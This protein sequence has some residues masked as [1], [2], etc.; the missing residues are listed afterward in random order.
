MS[1]RRKAERFRA[2]RVFGR[3]LAAARRLADVGSLRRAPPARLERRNRAPHHERTLHSDLPPVHRPPRQR[4]RARGARSPARRSSSRAAPATSAA[5][6]SRG[7]LER[8]YRV[9]VLD[10][11]YLGEDAAGGLPRPHRGGP[12]PTCATSPPSALD[13]V[14]GVIHLAGLSNDPTA[15]YDPE[16][17]WQMNAVATETLGRACVERGIER[18][19]FASS[20]SLYDGLPP[21]MHDETRRSSR[22]APTRPPSATA[23]RRCSSSVDEGLCPVILRNGTVYGWSPRMRFDLVVNTFVKDALLNGALLAARRR[24]DVAAARRRARLRRRD[25]RRLEAPAEKVRGEIFNVLHSNY[26]IRELAML[27]AG[28][29]QLTRPQGRRSTEAPAPAAHARLRVLEREALDARS[30][31][32]R[33]ARC[34]EAVTDMLARIDVEDRATL[35]DPR[36]YNI[37]WLELLHELKP[38]LERFA[39]GPVSERVLITGGGGQLGLRPRGA[40]R[41]RRGHAF[42]HAELDITDD[43]ALDARLRRG[44]ARRRLQLRRVPQRRRLRDARRTRRFAVN[45]ARRAASWPRARPA[46]A[47]P[48]RRPTTSSTGAAT[49]PTARTTCPRPRSRSTRSPSSPASTPRWPTAPRALVVRTAGLYGLHGSAS[50]GGNFVQRM[51]ARAREQ[52]ALK[53]VADQRLQPTFT[54]DLRRRDRRGARARGRPASL[55]LT[56]AGACSWHE[57]TR[58]DHGARRRRRAESRRSRRRSAPAA[59]TGR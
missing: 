18:F 20:C 25:D 37:R 47:R 52:G 33:A 49:S 38:R 34:V 12:R 59:P 3:T 40:A 4:A 22:A 5:C 31:S 55:H 46:A 9:R 28:S 32:S 45:V 16:A 14:D 41:R 29:V 17:N 50:K 54:A 23:R 21:G 7:L 48:P 27:V 24:L 2:S 15:E 39:S 11:L 6:S 10:R 51:L 58:G 30:A 19:V 1:G 57:F 26:Q 53:M 43:A 44:R 56:A 42:S 13:G 8:G 35:T 36:Y